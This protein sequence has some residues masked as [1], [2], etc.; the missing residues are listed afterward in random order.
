MNLYPGVDSLKQIALLFIGDTKVELCPCVDCGVIVSGDVRPGVD[1][2]KQIA[3]LFF[4]DDS[5]VELCPC[6]DCGVI[7]SGDVRPGFDSLIKFTLI[8][9]ASS[10]V[11]PLLRGHLL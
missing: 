2:L 6:V 5:E 9:V 1:S 3:L 8:V 7:V 10:E 11:K 4:I